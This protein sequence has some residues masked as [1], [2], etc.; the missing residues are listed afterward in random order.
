MSE[1]LVEKDDTL[2]L[3][4]LNRP[5]RANSLSAELTELLHETILESSQDGTRTLVLR[6]EGESFCSG[7][8]LSDLETKTDVEIADRIL[9]VE[10]MLQALHHAPMTTVALVQSKAFGAG[11]DMVCSCHIRI[12][13]PNSV[14]CMPGLNFGILLGTRRLSQR[15]GIDNTLSILTNTRV[16]DSDEALKMGFLTHVAKMKDWDR[17]IEA[18]KRVGA[19][20]AH[21]DVRRM[22]EVVIPDSRAEDLAD[23][24][25]S[26]EK[27]GLIKRIVDYRDSLRRRSGK[28]VS[29]NHA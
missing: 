16:F 5:H 23:L 28:P 19:A 2:K 7:F 24:R 13:E 1:L 12:A 10:R 29:E 8:D 4:R 21:D 17:H 18:A 26:V 25:K 20:L 22:F 11:A 6:G 14:F 15:V 9:R 27:E 3:V